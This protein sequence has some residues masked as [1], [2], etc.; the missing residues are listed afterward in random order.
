MS[1]ALAFFTIYAVC[2]VSLESGG[3]V[4][5][6]GIVLTD[7]VVLSREAGQLGPSDLGVVAIETF[8]AGHRCNEYCRDRY[9]HSTTLS[10]SFS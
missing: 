9:T 1:S 6:N 5:P 3:V 2:G 4:H 8:F 7:P 10:S